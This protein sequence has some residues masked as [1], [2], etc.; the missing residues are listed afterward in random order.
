[1]ALFIARWPDGSAWI[2][3]ADSMPE[4]A[5]ILDEVADPGACEVQEYDGPFAIEMR[6]AAHHEGGNP[7]SFGPIDGDTSYEMQ[8]AILEAAFPHLRA[9]MESARGEDGSLEVSDAAWSAAVARET[10][11]DL[12]ASSEW[13]E[14]VRVWWEE[15]TGAPADRSAALRDMQG[16]TIPGE[17]KIE[18]PEQREMFDSM[19][20]RII[21]RVAEQLTSPKTKPPKRPARKRPAPK[22][23]R[24]KS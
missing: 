1:M 19:Q 16:V 23:P 20:S 2:V 17:P 21:Q 5:E 10:D 22:R 15:R 24:K 3:E 12:H 18:T 11:R 6:P 13:A 14:S 8:E 7:F 9:D 4:V